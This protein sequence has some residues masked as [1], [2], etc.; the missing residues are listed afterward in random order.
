M[1]LYKYPFIYYVK[2]KTIEQIVL[3][4]SIRTT[5]D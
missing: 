5:T 3:L 2:H 1:Y 4:I